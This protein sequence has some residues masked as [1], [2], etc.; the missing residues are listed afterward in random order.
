[1]LTTRVTRLLDKLPFRSQLGWLFA[2]GIGLLAVGTF[3][4]SSWQVTARVQQDLRAQGLQLTERLAQ[5]SPLA[6]LTGAEENA[7]ESIK[8]TVGF[9][10]VL[11]VE[12]YG[13]KKEIVFVHGSQVVGFNP[14]ALFPELGSSAVL[15]AE[16]AGA[17]RFVAPVQTEPATASPFET[18]AS[19]PELLGC[20]IVYV[21]KSAMTDLANDLF[22]ASLTTSLLFAFI[23]LTLI[24]WVM[25]Y[26]TLPLERLA[27]AMGRAK[28][29]DLRARSPLD[30]PRDIAAMAQA[31]NAMISALED[32][33]VRLRVARDEALEFARLKAA[34]A[35]TVSHEVRTPMNGVLGMLELLKAASLRP[36]ER[37]FVEVAWN[38]AQTLLVLIN[39]ILDFSKLEAGKALLE[40]E[41]FDPC[42]T[43]EDVL[44]LLASQAQRKGL[45]LGH[46]STVGLP[47]QVWG[48]PQRFRQIVTNL[49]SNAIKFTEHGAVQIQVSPVNP[50]DALL[51][52]WRFS[53]KDTGI[54][55]AP[56][57]QARLFESFEQADPSTTRKFGGTGLGLSISRQLVLLM[58]GEIGVC[59][60]L[61]Q[62]SEFWFTLPLPP[63]P[64]PEDVPLPP[65]RILVADASLL[66]RQFLTGILRAW[67]SEVQAV[68]T[69]T[70]TLQKLQ[71]AITPTSRF[72]WLI[73]ANNLVAEPAQARALHGL[74]QTH[75]AQLAVMD[76]FG[77]DIQRQI[78]PLWGNVNFLAKPLRRSRLR[79]CL[80][81]TI[82]Q[83]TQ[84][85]ALAIPNA[86]GTSRQILVVEDNRANQAV[87]VGMLS[88]LGH[89]AVLASNGVEALNYLQQQAFDLV[90]MD[91]NMP[92]MDGYE[93]TLRIRALTPP[94]RQRM[95]VIAMTANTDGGGVQRCLQAGMDDHL[96]K[97]LSLK[98][99]TA[100]LLQWLET[101]PT[102]VVESPVE[103]PPTIVT[104]QAPTPTAVNAA[105]L[106]ELREA[107]GEKL[108]QV[109]E[110]F[111]E[112]TP[113]YLAKL[114]A[115]SSANDPDTLR[116]VAHTIKGIAGSLGATQ[117]A[118][119][120][121]QIEQESA[122]GA[123]ADSDKLLQQLKAEYDLVQAVLVTELKHPI[124]ATAAVTSTNQPLVLVVDDDRVT[125]LAL[126]H[127]LERDG[128]AV[129]EADDGEAAVELV[130]KMDPDVVLMD[131]MMPVLNGFDACAKIQEQAGELDTPVLMI[132]ALDDTESIAKA[133][134]AG[135][136][137][138][139]TKP[140][141]LSVVSQRV[142][143]I[144]EARRTERYV[145]H[146]AYHD[147][148]TQLA[149]RVTFMSQLG[150]HLGKGHPLAVL[151]LDLDR[152]KLVNDTLGHDIGDQL[153][154]AVAER[155]RLNTRTSD[156]VA[157]FGGDEFAVLLG[158][159]GFAEA[160]VAM[161]EK[162]S[163]AMGSAFEIEGHDIFVTASVGIALYPLDGMDAS[164]LLKHADTAMYQAKR[165]GGGHAFY[166]PDMELSFSGRLT[167]ESGLRR[168]LERNELIVHYQPKAHLKRGQII[169]AEA[170]VRWQHPQRGMIPPN[171]FI[172][173][174]E[175]TGLILPIGQWVLRTACTQAKLWNGPGRPPIAV[176][177]NLSGLQ[178]KQATIVQCVAG[179]LQATG[180]DPA[181]LELEI[182]ES[183]LMEQAGETLATLQQLKALGI[184][185]SIDDFGTGYSSLA[186]LKRFPVDT[187]KIDHTFVR[188]ILTDPDGAAII[189]GIIALAH[190]LR[191][192]V[193][194]EGVETTAQREFL[195]HQDCDY[196]QG[197][198]LAEPLDPDQFATRFLLP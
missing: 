66:S 175:E 150:R 183:V 117:L 5:Q 174:A 87:A 169:G 23:F 162:I 163:H 191:L 115:A 138:Y 15:D 26:A 81:T 130:A 159:T 18:Q 62:G 106:A 61:G 72:D 123:L 20:A 116:Q 133:F 2:L 181:L 105:I 122:V 48:D 180:L 136:S 56:A 148:L 58:G 9:P 142:R 7:A 101:S 168:A 134:A 118:A 166:K 182:T 135:A 65:L 68:E 141:N 119:V 177:V 160:A 3:L 64:V 109:I 24:R 139:L 77:T 1:M 99:L 78:Q 112:D 197:Y 92:V 70:Q 190:S 170:L 172:P 12:I 113:A 96:A 143:R 90:L 37:E 75:R 145:R 173:L 189:T 25:R 54:G 49:V 108:T 171:A 103:R 35:A 102:E 104:P 8:A 46:L 95:P 85:T 30:G 36:Q 164:T 55:I 156:C 127:A 71:T 121:R 185:L 158:E 19:Q 114:S 129:Q 53:V 86:G 126:R 91:C 128:F 16:T 179:V 132:T 157:R 76:N 161:A 125:R 176:A 47:S 192:E 93:A 194:A 196:I 140:L 39:D 124:K 107:L 34:F 97:P 74:L 4:V 193:V 22:W 137:D 29:G 147:T 89:R 44:D 59:S 11:R 28:D 184:S 83:V 98:V 120:A 31:F 17:W 50:C 186:Y 88:V 151:F 41:A 79:S 14:L 188:E 131:A 100:K 154:K 63:A 80:S 13:H 10:G 27:D 167:L 153:L 149:N 45:D 52:Y 111:L 110:L 32:R 21:S 82:A 146:L 51:T 144:V 165:Q 152:F 195:A 33:E 57:D 187:L 94:T 60:A 38:S 69:L 198:L 6:L 43:I 42:A 84:A 178:L 67:G 155:I 40:N 73:C